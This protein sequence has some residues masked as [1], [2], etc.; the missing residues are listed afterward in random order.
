[1]ERQGLTDIIILDRKSGEERPLTDK[2][3]ID[4]PYEGSL[5]ASPRSAF[6]SRTRD[7]FDEPHAGLKR[8]AGL[9]GSCTASTAVIA[10]G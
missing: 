5:Y 1:M 8:Q 6:S 3:F 2:V 4:A 9:N 7:K 10:T